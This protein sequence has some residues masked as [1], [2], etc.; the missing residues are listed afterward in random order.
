MSELH[1]VSRLPRY[2]QTAV[3]DGPVITTF[4]LHWPQGAAARAAVDLASD[5][6]HSDFTKQRFLIARV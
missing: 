3:L 1:S 5:M 2:V 4:Q 6:Y